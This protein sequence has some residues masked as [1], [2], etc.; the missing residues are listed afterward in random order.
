MAFENGWIESRVVIFGRKKK[1]PNI[2]QGISKVEI[3]R[4]YRTSNKEFPM[5]NI[6]QAM[7]KDPK[8]LNQARQP[9]DIQ[10]SLFDIQYSFLKHKK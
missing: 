1:I 8:A 4:E 7:P 3:L 5:S 2:E 10:H 6:E 9:F